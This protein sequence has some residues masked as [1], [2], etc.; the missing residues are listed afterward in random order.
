MVLCVWK[1]KLIWK[2]EKD[3]Q[4]MAQR[5][6]KMKGNI[7]LFGTGNAMVLYDNES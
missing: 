5:N 3:I 7:G 6:L 2:G 4:L 1:K